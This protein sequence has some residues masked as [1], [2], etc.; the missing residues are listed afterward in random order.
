MVNEIKG[1][2]DIQSKDDSTRKHALVEA[3]LSELYEGFKHQEEFNKTQLTHK[4]SVLERNLK[5][6]ISEQGA[7]LREQLL[8]QQK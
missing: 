7:S 8:H 4:L 6:E 2:L 1:K 5:Q 3:R